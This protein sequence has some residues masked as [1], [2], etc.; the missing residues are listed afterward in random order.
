MG[1][2][3]CQVNPTEDSE[4]VNQ[5]L[6]NLFPDSSCIRRELQMGVELNI[7]LNEYQH[8]ENLRLMIHDMRIIDAVRLRLQRNW[9]GMNTIIH[10]DK[11]VAYHHKI[12]LI[13]DSEEEPPL[14]TIEIQLNFDDE[15]G[16][17]KF[18]RWFTPPTQNGKVMMN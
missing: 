12:R 8:I 10:L 1:T 3:R 13:D 4:L 5:A 15:N 14:G 9:N 7:A 11:Q 18:L 6:L 2:V 17:E 16:F